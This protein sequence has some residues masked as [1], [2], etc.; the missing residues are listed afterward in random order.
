[1]VNREL[2]KRDTPDQIRS[3]VVGAYLGAQEG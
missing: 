1:M 3:D 2:I